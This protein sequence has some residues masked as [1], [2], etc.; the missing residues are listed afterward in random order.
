[1]KLALIGYGKMGKTIEQVAL[2]RGHTIVLRI[3]SANMH[4]MNLKQLSRADVAI[5]FTRPDSA[6]ENVLHCLSAGVNVICGTTGWNGH[7]P[8][9]EECALKNNAAFLFSSNFSI[10]VNMFFE[11]NKK[12]ALLMNGRSDYQVII[13]ETHHTQKK[14][15]PSGTAVTLAQQIIEGRGLENKWLLNDFTNPEALPIISHRIGAVPGTHKI[16]YSSAIDNLEITHTAHSRDGFAH[17]AVLAA[18]FIEG[19]KGIFSMQDVLGIN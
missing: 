2:Q 19:K 12:L 15:A 5:E 7:L 4:E 11:I 1:M 16:T 18:E 8:E 14:D 6:R 13:E 3:T 10:G 17:G 9:A